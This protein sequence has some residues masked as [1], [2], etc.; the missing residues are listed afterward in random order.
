MLTTMF[1]R[2]N[3]KHLLLLSGDIEVNP[4]S[5]RSSKIK[6][7]HWNLNEVAAHD[8]IKVPLIEG[9]IT[10]SNFD[11]VYLSVTFL[12]STIPGDDENIQINGYSLLRAD[13]PND[14]KHRGVCI[15]FKEMLPLIRRNDLTNLKNCLVAEINVNNEKRFFTRLYRSSSQ[16]YDELKLISTN[17]DLLLSNINNIYPTCSIFLGDFNAKCSKW[18]ASNK[19]N[20][21]GI[22]LDNIT[23]TSG[24]NEMIDTPT[25]HINESSSCIDLIFS[26]N[27]NLAKNCGVKQSPK[28]SS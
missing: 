5:K 22:E 15:Y 17:F 28:M 16:N 19:Y 10:T 13:H 9:F 6:F 12:D 11:I 14:T 26:S 24:Y 1:F 23:M 27:V 21:T 18:C 20:T 8:F 7:C 2:N 3:F 4:G 25:H